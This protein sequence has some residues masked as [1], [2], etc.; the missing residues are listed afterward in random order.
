MNCKVLLNKALEYIRKERLIKRV[1]LYVFG[2]FVLATGV[3]LTVNANLGISVV[4]SI[5]FMVSEILGTQ[6]GMFVT[7]LL[8]IFVLIE[9]IILRRNFKLAN[10]LEIVPSFLFGY[11]VDLTRWLVSGFNIPTYAGQVVILLI[12]SLTISSGLVLYMNAKLISMPAEGIVVVIAKQIPN[13]TFPKVKVVF[14]SVLVAIGIILSLSYFGH[15]HGVREGT[16]F[17]AMGTGRIMPLVRKVIDP[18]LKKIGFY[19]E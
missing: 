15:L 2:L 8:I 6:M 13:G 19:F 9:L 16:L 12:A 17:L 5:P 18:T 7:A 4:N 11:F 3:S 10:A 1:I 14:D